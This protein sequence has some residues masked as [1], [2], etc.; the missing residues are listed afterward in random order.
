MLIVGPKDAEQNGVSVRDRLEGD[1][2][3]MTLDAAVEK[4]VAERD[5]RQIRQ[6]VRQTF[7]GFAEN[8]GAEY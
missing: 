7:S 5:S 8:S 3:F 1:L 4:L 6:V 2:G